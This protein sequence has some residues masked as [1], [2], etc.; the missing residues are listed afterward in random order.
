[1]IELLIEYPKGTLSLHRLHP[2]CCYSPIP[3]AIIRNNVCI[4]FPSINKIG[5]CLSGKLIQNDE[6]ITYDTNVFLSKITA[7]LSDITN[8]I[9]KEVIFC[10][11]GDIN[12]DCDISSNTTF[13][14][15]ANSNVYKLCKENSSVKS[16]KE[17]PKKKDVIVKG[18]NVTKLVDDYFLNHAEMMKKLVK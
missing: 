2:S 18:L 10:D 3:G 16:E 8:S 4:V 15:K 6:V 1:M 14:A 11:D 12:I 5:C 7:N 17:N 13:T 9:I